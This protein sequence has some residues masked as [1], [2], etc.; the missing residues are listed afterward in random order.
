MRRALMFAAALAIVN[1]SAG[2]HPRAAASRQDIPVPPPPPRK[3]VTLESDVDARLLRV[4]RWLTALLHHKPGEPDAA[5][6]EVSAWSTGDLRQ[7]W[8]DTNVLARLIRNPKASSFSLRAEGQPPAQAIHYPPVAFRRLQV[9]A[10]VAGGQAANP[11]L[12]ESSSR[13]REIGALNSVDADLQELARRAYA[14]AQRHDDNY[15]LRR[16]AILEG[17]VAMLLPGG[18]EPISTS[19]GP[20]P[21]RFRMNLSDGQG[22]AFRR[23]AVH[24]ELARMLL[25]YIKPVGADRVAPGRDDMVRDWYRATAAWMQDRQD[26]DDKHLDRAREIFSTDPIILF[27][28]GTQAEVFAAPH[29]QSAVRSAVTPPGATFGVGS[30]R[31]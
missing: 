4:Q 23:V 22:L 7:L 28:S 2:T 10:C 20:A 30:D 27:L 25:D 15:I 11:D 29:I 13:C 1:T 5:A 16:G 3:A 26:Y 6:K 18:A 19:N 17:D 14:S 24:W 9:L 12:S 31:A 8:I 21:D